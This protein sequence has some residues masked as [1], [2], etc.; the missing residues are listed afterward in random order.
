MKFGLR[1]KCRNSL[2]DVEQT[3]TNT[4]HKEVKSFESNL[5]PTYTQHYYGDS[6]CQFKQQ[7]LDYSTY[8][9]LASQTAE[10][11]ASSW[12]YYYL[13]AY[14]SIQQTEEEYGLKLQRQRTA[15]FMKYVLHFYETGN[16]W[17]SVHPNVRRL[18]NN[19][20]S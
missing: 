4:R 17:P 14:P 5:L 9:S 12:L 7:F 13:F 15:L 16:G 6:S 11:D 3:E 10:D 8:Y 1:L 19:F 2:E 20:K 18:N